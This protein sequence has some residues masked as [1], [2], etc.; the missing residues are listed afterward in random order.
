MSTVFER[1]RAIVVEHRDQATVEP[2]VADHLV[3]APL[4]FQGEVVSV[5]WSNPHVRFQVSTQSIDGNPQLWEVE[6]EDLADSA[7]RDGESAGPGAVFIGRDLAERADAFQIEIV[8]RR[9]RPG[10]GTLTSALPSLL[11]TSQTVPP[12]AA[13][14]LSFTLELV[15]SD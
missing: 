14:S 11:R 6:G 12:G 15:Q 8:G 3:G 1:V 9:R 10:D 4:A 13:P 2:A 5:L 7:W